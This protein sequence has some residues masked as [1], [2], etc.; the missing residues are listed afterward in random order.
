[1]AKDFRKI[2]P[3]RLHW[4]CGLDVATTLALYRWQA[5]NL[6]PFM[7]TWRVLH[8]PALHAL[9]QVERWGA[10][11][12]EDNVRA[13]DIFLQGRIERV[14]SDLA[15]CKDVPADLN[16][17]SPQQ[18]RKLFFETLGLKP[19]G[20]TGTG[21]PSCDDDTL[22]ELEKQNP[23]VKCI[24]LI[25]D[26]A[27]ARSR[28]SSYGLG[29]MKHVGYDGRVHTKYSIIRSGRLSSKEPNLQNL[30]SPD[31]DPDVADEENET[32]ARGCWVPPPGWVWVNLDYSQVELRIAA[33]L[34]GDRAMIDAFNSGVD[35]HTARA[36]QIFAKTADKVTK[37]ER[38]IAKVINFMIPYGATDYGVARSLK[39]TKEKAREYIDAYLESA[40]QFAAWLRKQVSDGGQSGESWAIYKPEGWVHRR[41]VPDMGEPT[42]PGMR[43]DPNQKRVEHAERVCKNNPIQNIANCFSLASLARAVAWIEDTGIPA[44]LNLTVHDNL[45]L[46][47]R[48]DVWQEVAVNV[49]R[50][51]QGYETGPVKLKVDIEKGDRESLAHGKSHVGARG[52]QDAGDRR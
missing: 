10:I 49:R 28:L 51:M 5:Q 47:A 15:L 21:L 45:A 48:A 46:Y 34:S 6:G 22:E 8:Q 52:S 41:P 31:D 2:P 7:N 44:E 36:C 9:G 3:N 42:T 13:Y 40:P 25:R 23:E 30:K 20:R 39:I 35:F 26:L 38:R 33:V 17:K 50:I 14:R 19:V 27:M 29:Q 12:S 32:Q 11:L 1:V 18:M 37:L 43:N 4:Y 16:V 24:P